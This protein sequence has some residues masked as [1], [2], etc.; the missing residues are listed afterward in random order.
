MLKATGIR[1]AE[2]DGL[3]Y[4]PGDPRRSD[5]DLRQREITVRGKGGKDRIVLSVP[6]TCA[7][8][9]DALRGAVGA[10]A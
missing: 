2:L 3:R 6:K 9:A 4:D 1:L 8:W 10:V 5:I 7:T